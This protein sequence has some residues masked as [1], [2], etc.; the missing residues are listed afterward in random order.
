MKK[1]LILIISLILSIIVLTVIFFNIKPKQYFHY[2]TYD[3]IDS[4]V[5]KNV[6]INKKCTAWSTY[7]YECSIP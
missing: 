6:D 2:V 4:L 1:R 7:E 5:E 3:E